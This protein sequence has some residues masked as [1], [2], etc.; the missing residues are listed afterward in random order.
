[1][2]SL[3]VSV[4][5]FLD[6]THTRKLIDGLSSWSESRSV[7]VDDRRCPIEQ[8]LEVA[9]PYWHRGGFSNKAVPVTSRLGTERC[10]IA[11]ACSSSVDSSPS[12]PVTVHRDVGLAIVIK[13][14]FTYL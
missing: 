13:L 6:R 11:T 2:Q 3:V 8:C 7:G 12:V 9:L 10:A 1:M 14:P 4:S 5:L